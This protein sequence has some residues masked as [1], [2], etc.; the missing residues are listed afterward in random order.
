MNNQ[1]NYIKFCLLVFFCLS[2]SILFAQRTSI[3][4]FYGPSIGYNSIYDDI[5]NYHGLLDF[6]FPSDGTLALL[7]DNNLSNNIEVINGSVLGIRF[8]MPI[9]KGLSIQPELE[10]Q[11]LDFNHIVYQNGNDVIF[12]DLIFTLSGLENNG[13]YKIANYFW[14]VNYLNFPFVLKLYPSDNL[15]IQAGVKFG[16]LLKA[17]E[18][19]VIGSFDVE[20]QEYTSY[21]PVLDEKVIYEFFD[22]DSGIDNH[23][24]DK[25]EWPFSW[26]AAFLTGVG[27]ETKSFYLALRYSVGLIPFF[28]EIE[29]KDDDFFEIYNSTVDENTYASFDVSSPVLNNNFKLRAIHFVIG[30]SLS[31]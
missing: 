9:I 8:N 18:S 20:T 23:G 19:R 17:E 28:K 31:N 27:Y 10:Y 2:L 12:N 24:F 5:G 29:N 22:S 21:V 11:Q 6:N 4:F 13:Q 30:F 3:G 14:R 25:D 26:N 15:F 1:T 7:N 16:F